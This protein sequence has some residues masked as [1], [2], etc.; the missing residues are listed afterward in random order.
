MTRNV[1]LGATLR[2][3]ADIV[4]AF[5]VNDPTRLSSDLSRSV[6][7]RPEGTKLQVFAVELSVAKETLATGRV[8]TRHF[9]IRLTPQ[10]GG[11]VRTETALRSKRLHRAYKRR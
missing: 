8:R 7:E 9:L 1:A 2:P 6:V 5:V 4:W 10:D 11:R 3:S